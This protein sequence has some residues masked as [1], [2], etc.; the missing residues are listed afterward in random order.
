M[1]DVSLCRVASKRLDALGVNGALD[2]V[3]DKLMIRFIWS[4]CVAVTDSLEIPL[5]RYTIVYVLQNFR[6]I[7][8]ERQKF[9]T[10]IKR[11][12]VAPSLVVSCYACIQ[13]IY[14]PHVRAC[15]KKK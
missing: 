5:V 3:D 9:L 4:N 15:S 11:Y 1:S 12:Y 8:I 14:F 2:S 6:R 13:H 7:E 10:L